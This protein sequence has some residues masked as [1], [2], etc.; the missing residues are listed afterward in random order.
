MTNNESIL[1]VICMHMNG[2][3]SPIWEESNLAYDFCNIP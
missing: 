2:S 3:E 1:N